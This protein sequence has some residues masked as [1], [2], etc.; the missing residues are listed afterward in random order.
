MINHCLD[1]E[2]I[3]ILFLKDTVLY[4]KASKGDFEDNYLARNVGSADMVG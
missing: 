2:Y 4:I 3:K 1:S